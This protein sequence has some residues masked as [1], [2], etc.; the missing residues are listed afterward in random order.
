MIFGNYVHGLDLV[1]GDL[2]FNGFAGIDVALLNQ[3]MTLHND[4]QLPPAVVPVLTFG[5]S[6]L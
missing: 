6:G 3:A 1:A 2:E 4:E 5:D